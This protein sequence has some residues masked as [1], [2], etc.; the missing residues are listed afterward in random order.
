MA[1]RFIDLFCGCGGLSLG[2]QEAGF[3]ILKSFDNWDK[4]VDIY[5]KNF[6]HKAELIDAYDL[7]PDA[8]NSYSPDII[9]GGPPCQDYSSAGKRNESLGRANLTIRFAE[10]VASLKTPWFV[11]ENVYNIE[12]S[13]VFDQVLQIFKNAG[14]EKFT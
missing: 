11:M 4:A 2:F 1:Y 9:I 8:L 6:T 10:I 3:E 14:Y 12:R 7:T 13:P 5:N